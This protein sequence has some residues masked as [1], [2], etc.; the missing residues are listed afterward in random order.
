MDGVRK[1]LE[2]GDRLRAAKPPHAPKVSGSLV[3]ELRATVPIDAAANN[4][5]PVLCCLL[6]AFLALGYSPEA[7]MCGT[8]PPA[9]RSRSRPYRP[10]W[11][12]T[13]GA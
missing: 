9:G 11:R 10:P 5:N 1:R 2:A 12:T 6:I 4:S 7:A 8:R 13:Y 3:R